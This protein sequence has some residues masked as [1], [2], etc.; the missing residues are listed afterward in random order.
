MSEEQTW[1]VEWGTP[2]PTHFAKCKVYEM[3]DG[4]H[5]SQMERAIAL[6]M[7]GEAD[8]TD[9]E[10]MYLLNNYPLMRFGLAAA[11]G[12]SLELTEEEFWHLPE[13]FVMQVC[14]AIR[15]ANPQYNLPFTELLKTV[16]TSLTPREEK[17]P[18]STSAPDTSAKT[19]SDSA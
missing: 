9:M 8:D 6:R 12:F 19:T 2:T 4:L 15:E 11:E 16:M 3:R 13:G 7:K 17:P 1:D 18:D 14:E 5:K 10:L